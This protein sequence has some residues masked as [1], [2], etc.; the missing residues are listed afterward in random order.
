MTHVIMVCWQAV[1]YL[2]YRV[3]NTKLCLYCSGLISSQSMVLG[4]KNWSHEYLYDNLAKITQIKYPDN[5][6]VRYSYNN[7]GQIIS[8]E[9][10]D[11]Q[12]GFG[13]M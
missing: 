1:Q 5:S 7:L 4:V 12:L 6:S 9:R 3:I 11:T 10:Q 2:T 8:V 13:K